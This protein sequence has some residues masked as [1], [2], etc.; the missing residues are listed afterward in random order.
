VAN[1]SDVMFCRALHEALREEMARDETVFIFGEDVRYDIWDT[2]GNLVE[3]FGEN[4]VLDTPIAES[5]IVGAAIG[6]ALGGMRPVAEIMV[7]EFLPMAANQLA[8]YASNLQG[9]SLGEARLPLV[10]RTRFGRGAHAQNYEAW[11]MHLPGWKV[12]MPST[13]RDAKGMLK[14]A[15][16]DN[17]PVLFFEHQQLM[18]QTGPVPADDYTVPI[19]PAEIRLEGSDVTV[20]ATGQMVHRALRAAKDLQKDSIDVEV[21]DLRTIKPW[22][23]ETVSRS[24]KKTG[25]LVVVHEAWTTAGVG[26]E[27]VSRLLEDAD[28]LAALKAAPLRVGTPDI[29][30]WD[31][32]LEMVIPDERRIADAVRGTMKV[33]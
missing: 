16:R 5:S 10:V 28:A 27:V 33:V 9:R 2:T 31:T 1:T 24:L 21:I 14:S 30:V 11:F 4:R 12:V 32:Y 8:N 29:P 20:V 22:D 3:Q 7:A 19:G 18:R 13:P 23:Y 26:A 6:A 25:R 15:I 17:N